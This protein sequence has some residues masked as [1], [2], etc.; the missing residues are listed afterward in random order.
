MG[1][2]IPEGSARNR[3]RLKAKRITK[4]YMQSRESNGNKRAHSKRSCAFDGI[5]ITASNHKQLSAKT[6]R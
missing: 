2:E 5:N 1:N 3:R 6:E 4:R